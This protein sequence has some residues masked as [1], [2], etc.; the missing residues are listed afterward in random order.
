MDDVRGD[1]LVTYRHARAGFSLPLPPDWDL[2]EDVDPK[3]AMVAAEPD[4]G[5]G[6]RAN[7]VVT[8]DEVGTDMTA[9]DWQALNE[10]AS[11]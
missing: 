3:V 6:F 7:V 11:A 10:Q 8:V 2:K 1:G 4:E 9:N 5:E